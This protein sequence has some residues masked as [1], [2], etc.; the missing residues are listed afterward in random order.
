MT[1][2]NDPEQLEAEAKEMMEQMLKAAAGPSAED[3]RQEPETEFQEAPIEPVD[4]AEYLAEEVTNEEDSGDKSSLETAL[5]KAERA[6]KGAQAKMTHAT[7]EASELRR[8]NAEL[9]KTL[10]EM[11]GQLA[12]GQKDNERLQQLREDYP[13]FAPVLDELNRTQEEVQ[14]QRATL[15]AQ[16]QKAFEDAQNAA[17]DAH[18]ERIQAVH[19]D[20]ESITQTSDWSLWLDSQNTVI[21]EWVNSGTSNDVNAVLSQFKRDLGLDSSTPQETPLERA[22]AVAEPK[23]PKARKANTTGERRTWTV[24][25]IK[26]MSNEEFEKH[27]VEILSAQNQGRIRR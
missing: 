13:D 22:K 4:T 14:N 9:A 6:M 15:A 12:E 21:Q 27:Q 25:E 2:R 10:K 3:T 7:Q 17:Q 18:F 11:Q 24:D 20:V 1:R 8:Q 26:R 5:E 23:M 19:P 16:E